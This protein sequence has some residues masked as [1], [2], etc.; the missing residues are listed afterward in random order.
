M[1]ERPRLS[2]EA[3]SAYLVALLV[4][5]VLS[6]LGLSL[7]LVSQT[8]MQI[9]ANELTSHRALY[10]AEAGVQ[11]AIS[12]VLTV[13]SSVD[14]ATVPSVT[15]MTFVVPETRMTLDTSGNAVA[16]PFGSETNH[17][18]ERVEV[19]PFVPIRDSYCD[20]CPAA[21]GDVQLENV[22]HALVATSDRLSWTGNNTTPDT[23]VAS[24]GATKQL[25]LMVGI[26]PWWPPQWEA[27]ADQVQVSKVKQEA[28]N[29]VEQTT[30]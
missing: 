24:R 20:L 22:N 12:R 15:P 1:N 30:P 16:I 25:F 26:Q 14:N 3:G 19:S 8:E 18:A 2:S 17:F 21:E 6:I 9:G 29:R 5:I 28:L 11:M 27:I 13:N 23:T 7:A 10:G 4:L